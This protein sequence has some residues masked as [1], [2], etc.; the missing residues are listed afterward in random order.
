VITNQSG[1]GR[2]LFTRMD[3]DAVN[4]RMNELLARDGVTLDGLYM[5]PHAPDEG[6]RCRKPNT[7]LVEAAARDL[8]FDPKRSFMVG[9][10][11]I[12]M[13][14]GR[15]VGAVTILVRTGYGTAQENE[16]RG[17]IDLAVADLAA[18]A[19]FIETLVEPAA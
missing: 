4:T 13:A 10:K 3:A 9:D 17:D 19:R 12:D 1:I 7:G 18:A 2:G 5:C 8:S 14:L 16:S 15:R 11:A 6:C